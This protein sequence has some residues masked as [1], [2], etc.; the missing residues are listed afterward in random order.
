MT[1]G[2]ALTQRLGPSVRLSVR[3][4]DEACRTT[5]RGS[6]RVPRSGP[7]PIRTL[8][9]PALVRT[10][11]P[12]RTVALRPRLSIT[13]RRAIRRALSARRRITVVLT[14][15]ATDA[16]GN[17]RRLTRQIRVRL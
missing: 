17:T 7:G 4:R 5:V 14:I 11:R 13:T 10:L 2:G 15:T 1:L 6:V 12:G 9:L 8:R 16:V 3:C